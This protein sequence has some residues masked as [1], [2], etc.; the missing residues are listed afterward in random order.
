[1]SSADTFALFTTIGKVYNP[2][3]VVHSGIDILYMISL[4]VNACFRTGGAGS[5]RKEIGGRQYG[6]LAAAI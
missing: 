1:V 3:L 2:E 6:T 5:N 4:I